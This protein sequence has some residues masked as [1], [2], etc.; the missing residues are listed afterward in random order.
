MDG[1]PL[2]ETFKPQMGGIL[3]PSNFCVAAQLCL[4]VQLAFFFVKSLSF[5]LSSF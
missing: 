3:T 4:R 2:T 1:G 5:A